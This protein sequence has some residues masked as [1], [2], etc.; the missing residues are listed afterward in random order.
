MGE[1][2]SRAVDENKNEKKTKVSEAPRAVKDLLPVTLSA[3]GLLAYTGMDL[4]GQ[5]AKQPLAPQTIGMALIPYSLVSLALLA[6]IT[7]AP[8][9][10]RHVGDQGA[11]VMGYVDVSCITIVIA[12]VCASALEMMSLTMGRAMLLGAIVWGIASVS[13]I[14]IRQLYSPAP[15]PTECPPEVFRDAES[16]NDALLN[17]RQ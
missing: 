11:M 15:G 2:T 10:A 3:S 6:L 7:S 12:T 1:R 4:R 5:V 17:A 14:A 9:R 16:V 8:G 13:Q